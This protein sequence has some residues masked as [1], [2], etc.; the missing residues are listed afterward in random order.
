MYQDIS[1]P[2]F[3]VRLARNDA[4][5]REAQ[6]LRYEV[7]AAEGGATG[8]TVNHE[9]GIEADSFDQHADHLLLCDVTQPVGQQIVGTYRVMTSTQAEAA[10]G[11]YSAD[12]FDL[13]P[14]FANGGKV[15]ELGRSCLKK[16]YRGGSALLHLWRGLGQYVQ[17]HEIEVLFG[18]ASLPGTD[19]V[20]HQNVLSYLFDAHVAPAQMRPKA[21]GRNG[22]QTDLLAVEAIDRRAA[23]TQMPA[24]I[25]AYLRFG[26]VVG[27]GI[28]IDHA[29]NTIDICLILEAKNLSARQRALLE[30]A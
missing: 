1:S 9:Q 10:G 6:S 15:L 24:L 7:F 13:G 17:D 25:K 3:E 2:S 12:E 16:P 30:A 14:L 20:P 18:V 4:D 19:P 5:V 23:L 28:Y 21:V 8:K 11:F 26:G 29:F 22:A 27:D